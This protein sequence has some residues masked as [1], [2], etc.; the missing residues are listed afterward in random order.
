MPEGNY[1][2]EQLPGRARLALHENQAY[3][4]GVL[5]AYEQRCY[6]RR[7]LGMPTLAIVGMGRAG[8]D[9]AAAYL[10]ESTQLDYAGSS[11][12]RLCKF[13]ASMVGIPEDQAFAERHQHREFW[14][15]AGHAVRGFDLTLLARLTLG[16]GDM[17]IGIRGRHE[18]HGC[19]RDGV[20]N[21]V[22]WID[23]PRVA[24][25]PTVEFE[26]GD[27]DLIVPN[28]GAHT[29]LYRKLDKLAELLRLPVREPME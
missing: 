7:S 20:V 15:Q 23:N 18:L 29:E 19:R 25:D 27:C 1:S 17:A 2:F 8:K 16:F 3:V 6:R 4:A 12:N 10:G 26:A 14:I 11:S 24:S 13:V 5:K 22:V 28:H 9:T 21:A